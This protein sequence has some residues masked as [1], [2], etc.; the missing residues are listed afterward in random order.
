MDRNLH[1]LRA[2]IEGRVTWGE[3]VEYLATI[4]KL[5]PDAPDAIMDVT[6]ATET[7]IT[8]QQIL[9]LARGPRKYARVAIVVGQPTQFGLA[10]MYQIAAEVQ[11]QQKISLVVASEE[12]AMEW[13]LGPRSAAAGV[14]G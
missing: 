7:D 9:D 4:R 8:P 2:K 1:L 5:F 12:E 10:R 6:G 14:A 3:I 11:P 13:L